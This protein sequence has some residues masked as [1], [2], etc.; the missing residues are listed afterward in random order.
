MPNWFAAITSAVTGATPVIKGSSGQESIVAEKHMTDLPTNLV[1]APFGLMNS[2]PAAA[3]SGHHS[4]DLLQI[5]CVA[6]AD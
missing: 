3:G 5:D 6:A 4:F 1:I 2:A